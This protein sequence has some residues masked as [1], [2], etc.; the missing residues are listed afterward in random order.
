MEASPIFLPGKSHGQRSLAGYSPWGH[1]ESDTAERLTT[2]THRLQSV[3]LEFGIALS[4]FLPV[5]WKRCPRSLRKQLLVLTAAFGAA[6][7][8]HVC[9]SES[10]AGMLH[11]GLRCG[12]SVE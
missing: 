8:S 3:K 11:G 10:L 4:A 2:H 9:L 12:I 5:T 1:K 7:G 6:H